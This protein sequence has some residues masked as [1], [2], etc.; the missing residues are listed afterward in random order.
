MTIT[1]EYRTLGT[2]N[3]DATGMSRDF[4]REAVARLTTACESIIQRG[5]LDAEEELALRTFTNV[6]CNAF[7]MAPVQEAES[8]NV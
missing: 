3:P 2:F 8:T 5:L 7:D 4:K 6:V 1:P